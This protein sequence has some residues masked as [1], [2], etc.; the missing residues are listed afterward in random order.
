MCFC[1][2]TEDIEIVDFIFRIKMYVF[3][4]VFMHESYVKCGF[5]CILQNQTLMAFYDWCCV[6]F[7]I[8]ITEL[9]IEPLSAHFYDCQNGVELNCVC[10]CVSSSCSV[11]AVVY[12]LKSNFTSRQIR[13]SHWYLDRVQK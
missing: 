7:C 4:L 12:A 8:R 10:V 1:T 9:F 13:S 6:F 2:L 3:E 11:S 5:I